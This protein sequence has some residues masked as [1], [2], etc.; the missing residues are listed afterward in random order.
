[1]LRLLARGLPNKQIA[2][3]LTASPKT[4]DNHL[5]NIYSKINVSTRAARVSQRQQAGGAQQRRANS[6]RPPLRC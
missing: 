4:V 2:A 6:R 5:Q 1:V 3:Q